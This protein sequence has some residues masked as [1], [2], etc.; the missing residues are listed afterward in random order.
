[1]KDRDFFHTG[2]F[3]VDDII[4]ILQRPFEEKKFTL[5]DRGAILLE[6]IRRDD[7]V[8]DAGLIF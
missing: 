6:N 3:H 1:M 5:N 8:R 4:D 7:D 2:G